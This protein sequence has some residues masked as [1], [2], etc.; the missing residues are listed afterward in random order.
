MSPNKTE[1]LSNLQNATEKSDDPAVILGMHSTKDQDNRGGSFWTKRN[2]I[3]VSILSTIVLIAVVVGVAVGVTKNDDDSIAD[4]GLGGGSGPGSGTGSEMNTNIVPDGDGPVFGSG[5]GS[6][7]MEG[8]GTVQSPKDFDCAL[9]EDPNDPLVGNFICIYTGS[10]VQPGNF[11]GYA[12]GL[13][14]F[15]RFTNC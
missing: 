3:L 8:S 11:I 4:I 6:G 9:I 7:N 2:I 10:E 15:I 12:S 1:S 14:M 13:Y 5:S